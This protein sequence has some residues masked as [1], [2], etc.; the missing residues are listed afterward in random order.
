VN[1][2]KLQYNDEQMAHDDVGEQY[3]SLDERALVGLDIESAQLGSSEFELA[4]LVK[5]TIHR[6]SSARL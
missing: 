2:G 5:L 1:P 6:V 4:R 3:Q